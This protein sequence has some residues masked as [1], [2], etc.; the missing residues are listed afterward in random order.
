MRMGK[1]RGAK[2]ARRP[3]DT[4]KI[5]G[6]ENK[7]PPGVDRGAGEEKEAALLLGAALEL[8]GEL[9]DAT[10]GVHEALLAGVGDGSPS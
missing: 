10:R 6:S 2:P 3:V 4:E 8:R 7:K 9:L 5:A 1:G